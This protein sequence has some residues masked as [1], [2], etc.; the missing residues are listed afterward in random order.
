MANSPRVYLMLCFALFLLA[1]CKT[2]R[3]I[4]SPMKGLE[5]SCYKYILDFKPTSSPESFEV[6]DFSQ[7]AHDNFSENSLFFIRILGLTEEIETVLNH[8]FDDELTKF[9]NLQKSINEITL[10]ELEVQAFSS[11]LRCE[12]DKFNQLAWHLENISNSRSSTKTVSG[13]ILDA[14]AN[15]AGAAI[16]LFWAQ[17]NTT[18]QLIGIGASLTQ[19]YLNVW[20]RSITYT[21]DI[22]HPVNILKEFSKE[23]EWCESIPDH[24]WAYV[25]H[26]KREEGNL[27][28]RDQLMASWSDTLIEE[29]KDLFFSNGGTYDATQLRGRASMLEQLASFTEGMLQDLLI[30]RKE[31][32]SIN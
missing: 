23:Q 4:D 19:I 16:I 18:R 30:L 15:I 32:Q 25:N 3:S 5:E 27:N 17:G 8:E 20:G 31:L 14:S 12:E 7:K 28:I 29:N 11:A 22:E 24:I 1:S 10:I 2:V 21:V 9:K 6:D 13:I 26:V